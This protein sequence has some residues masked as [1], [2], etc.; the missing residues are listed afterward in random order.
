MNDPS[1]IIERRAIRELQRAGDAAVAPL[2]RILADPARREQH[3]KVG[4]ALVYLDE[5]AIEPLLG[6]LGAADPAL[7]VYVIQILAE[8]RARDAADYLVGPAA[9][10]NEDAA[11]REAAGAALEQIIGSRPH[12][13][14][15]RDHLIS[16]VVELL[17]GEL[18]RDPDGE[19]GITLWQWDAAQG[20]AVPQRYPAPLAGAVVAAR[21]AENLYA[22]APDLHA[23]R[24]H[25][26]AL[27]Q[28]AKIHNRL[29]LPL[30]RGEGT[31]HALAADFGPE[32]VED[33]LAEALRH[34]RIPAAIGAAEVLGDIGSPALVHSGTAAPA[35]L[36]AA[37]SHK[38]Q[39]LRL[40]AAEAI[41]RI[42]PTSAFPN[43]SRYIFTLART[44]Q[45]EALPRV[46]VAHPRGEVAQTLVGMLG[47]MGY[48]AE[49]AYTGRQAYELAARH[50]DTAML[51]LADSLDNPAVGPL[52]ELL[53]DDLRTANLPIGVLYRIEIEPV[54]YTND[55]FELMETAVESLDPVPG[56]IYR[57]DRLIH[58][59]QVAREHPLIEV[60]PEI[61]D[62]LTLDF[63]IAR[64]ATLAGPDFITPRERIYFA[65]VALEA[66]A[67]YAA[68]PVLY[69]FYEPA[70][71][72][73]A[74]IKAVDQPELSV[75]AARA[76]G[77]LGTARAQRSLVDV[78]SQH[79]RPIELRQ[80]AAVAFR[81]AVARE[82]LQLTT[83]EV[84]LQYQI[85]NLS[86]HLDRETQVVLGHVLDT[87]EGAGLEPTPQAA[88]VEEPSPAP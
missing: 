32:A 48:H 47:Q 19:G 35:P 11:V 26:Q 84:V 63:A 54:F 30:P 12:P 36:V 17:N 76:L 14:D 77:M 72:Q 5:Q 16:R 88:H 80:A 43:S 71:V 15:A 41:A 50:P 18:P 21:L 69:R 74:I 40:F 49:A 3:A 68:D 60:F 23:R 31:A 85:Y 39:R 22:I 79:G 61:R 73:E 52:V 42:N 46:I 1:P 87:I 38:N 59:R 58:A 70:R 4:R 2:V 53:R 29:D 82:H 65:Q 37:L 62:P 45:T 10:R 20:A 51:L 81:E 8:L 64:L 13:A 28:A 66:F 6:T 34:E 83:K 67:R 33:A 55:T 25:L 56:L 27:L 75:F 44:V 7:R 9:D 57:E 78:T 86:E 24:L